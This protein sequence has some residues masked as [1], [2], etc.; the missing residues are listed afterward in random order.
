M[1]RYTDICD[2]D[3]AFLAMT[4]MTVHELTALLPFFHDC[5]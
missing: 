3:Q 2:D 5:F 4:G 1:V